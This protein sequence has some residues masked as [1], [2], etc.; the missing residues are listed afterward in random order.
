MCIEYNLLKGI[1]QYLPFVLFTF[2]IASL[3]GSYVVAGIFMDQVISLD[4]L[5]DVCASIILYLD[6]FNGRI[7]S[8]TKYFEQ[9][10]DFSWFMWN[11]R[12]SK[13]NTSTIY[14]L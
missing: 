7:D 5:I 2:G 4:Y 10:F 8:I 14:M 12:E 13:K 1:V 9:F 6:Q 3:A 11:S